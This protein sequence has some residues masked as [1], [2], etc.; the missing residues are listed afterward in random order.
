M[1]ACLQNT[2]FRSI[3]VIGN[4][5]GTSDFRLFGVISEVRLTSRAAYG[6][7]RCFNSSG[8]RILYFFHLNTQFRDCDESW[9]RQLTRQEYTEN[10]HEFARDL[11]GMPV[12][13]LIEEGERGR[14]VV[15]QFSL[16]DAL[17]GSHV[18]PTLAHNTIRSELDAF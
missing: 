15:R 9:D 17:D 8:R 16:H 7:V 3:E 18:I 1:R 2:P 12:V 10:L 13:F 11:V 5:L 14:D 4:P 6:F